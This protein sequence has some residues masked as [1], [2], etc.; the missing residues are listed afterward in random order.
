MIQAINLPKYGPVIHRVLPNRTSWEG[1]KQKIPKL[2]F[3]YIWWQ[4]TVLSV[5]RKIC[6]K[7]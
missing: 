4:S 5:M 7:F 6:V 3:H 1:W 2:L